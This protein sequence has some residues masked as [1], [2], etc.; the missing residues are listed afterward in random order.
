MIEI[1]NYL[2]DHATDLLK[3]GGPIMGVLLVFL[4]SVIPILPLGAFI[5]LNMNAFGFVGGFLISWSATCIGCYASYFVFSS[6]L[7]K[8]FYQFLSRKDAKKIHKSMEKIRKMPLG[9]LAVL[10]ALPFTPAFLINIASGLAKVDRKKFLLSIL[11]GKIFIVYF[12]GFIG[13]SFLESMTDITT[14][15]TIAVMLVVAYL[16]SKY[17]SKK[18]NIK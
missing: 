9:N 3:M 8:Y 17:V 12:W 16:V 11:I 15:I 4:E 10:I 7:S 14:I 6:F 1:I 18:T 13:T 5:T 2:V